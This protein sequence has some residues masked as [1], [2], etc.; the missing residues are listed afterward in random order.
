LHDSI[1]AATILQNSGS[2]GWGGFGALPVLLL[3]FAIFYFL[4]I[5]PQQRR[6]KNGRPC[7]AA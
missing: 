3:M 4:L 1:L 5:L 7:S 2:T 6:Q